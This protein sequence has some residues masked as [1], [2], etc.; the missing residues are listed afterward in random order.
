MC[1]NEAA[2]WF[3][4]L[5]KE[6]KK[7]NQSMAFLE[8]EGFSPSLAHLSPPSGIWNFQEGIP[9][10]D[11]LFLLGRQ[12]LRVSDRLCVSSRVLRVMSGKDS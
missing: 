11:F 7:K 4:C 10:F 3:A 5:L 1:A 9:C 6:K 8:N 2:V 12:G